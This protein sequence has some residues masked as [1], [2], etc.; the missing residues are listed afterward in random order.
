MAALPVVVEAGAI[1]VL[2]LEQLSVGYDRAP[3]VRDLTLTVGPG[4]VVALLGA[5]GAGKPVTG[6]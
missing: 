5:N 6:L 1:D 4:E 2:E 3:V